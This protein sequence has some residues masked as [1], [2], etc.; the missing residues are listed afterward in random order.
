MEKNAST[1]N[2]K[3]FSEI[4]VAVLKDYEHSK[5]VASGNI[6][7]FILNQI[8]KQNIYE[9][10]EAAEESVGEIIR[11]IDEIES[12]YKDLQEW[13]RQGREVSNWIIKKVE[14]IAEKNSPNGPSDIITAM[15]IGMIA[16]NNQ[17]YGIIFNEDKMISKPF[18]TISFEGIHKR[19]MAS[20][21]LHDATANSLLTMAAMGMNI[22]NVS[23]SKPIRA[24][25]TFFMD[26]LNSESDSIVK[27]VIATAALIAG[28]KGVF[29]SIVP[30]TS[31][32]VIA[33]IAD[34]GASVAKMAYK[35]GKGQFPH[36]EVTNYIVDRAAAALITI[37]D[38]SSEKVGGMVGGSIGTAIGGVFGP[39]GAAAGRLIGQ[40]IGEKAG[41]VIGEVV[42]LGIEKVAELAKSELVKTVCEI[43]D[44]VP[45]T[46]S[47]AYKTFKS[48]F[49]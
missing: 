39:G 8:L 37:V 30:D 18:E 46:I 32:T 17:L 25:Q 13:R 21:L 36:I 48:W 9:S 3:N 33:A 12:N 42:K 1:Q 29:P 20:D 24:L 34:R 35:I 38:R 27:K 45:E 40:A 43:V 19:A 31:A 11:T 23:N 44:R 15:K 49:N 10:R 47:S 2:E 6:N 22:P 4:L 28:K 26:P 16:A 41:R 14:T 7:S 5:D